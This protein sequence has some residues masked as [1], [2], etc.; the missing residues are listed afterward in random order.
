[1][2]FLFVSILI[3]G[4][5]K[6]NTS[7]TPKTPLEKLIAE[8]VQKSHAKS[9]IG[10]LEIVGTASVVNSTIAMFVFDLN[11][12][13]CEGL[14]QINTNNSKVEGID[15]TVIDKNSSFT[16]HQFS[17]VIDN[18]MKR[19]TFL[20]IGGILND[21]HIAGMLLQFND[22]LL[23]EAKIDSQKNEYFYTRKDKII[24]LKQ[25]R[26]LDKSGRVLSEYPP[27]PPKGGKT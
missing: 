20:A 5:S 15:Y 21:R 9:R 12:Q 11:G 19:N 18:G 10:E 8:E 1:M 17:G 22:G 3:S 24:S 7:F 6:T 13:Q 2:L 14:S 27:Y 4:C 16:V 26:A 25:I 23:V